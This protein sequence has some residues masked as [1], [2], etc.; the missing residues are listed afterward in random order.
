MPLTAT[1]TTNTLIAS[2]KRHFKIDA[3]A[4]FSYTLS[5]NN[6]T[7]YNLNTFTSS[8][9]MKRHFHS[10]NTITIT[11]SI[12][13]S[14]NTLTLSLNHVQTANIDPGRYMYDV[15]FTNTSNVVIRFVEGIITVNPA[16]S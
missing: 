3:G 1:L 4:D 8:A 12:N 5:V 10:S 2:S 7:S 15:K 11:S 13:A 6:A 14:A 9:A 16:V